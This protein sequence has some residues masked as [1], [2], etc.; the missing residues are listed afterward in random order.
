MANQFF[1]GDRYFPPTNNFTRLKLT[2]TKNFYQLLFL[3]KGKFKKKREMSHI[4]ASY[5]CRKNMFYNQ[6][7]L[8]GFST[9]STL[10]LTFSIASV[11]P[12]EFEL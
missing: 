7:S 5:V 6:T 2:L 4:I 9:F 3:L 12:E 8:K 10:S 1:I 11:I